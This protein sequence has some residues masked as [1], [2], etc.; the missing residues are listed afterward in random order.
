M[1]VTPNQGNKHGESNSVNEEAVRG[2]MN[3]I[4]DEVNKYM[5]QKNNHNDST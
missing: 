3:P 2:G 5:H 1:Y 4:N